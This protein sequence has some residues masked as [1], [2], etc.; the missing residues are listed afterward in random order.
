MK[1]SK[2]VYDGSPGC[3]IEDELRVC[4]EVEI[5]F[6]QGLKNHYKVVH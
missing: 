2:E 4:V 6:V 1:V 3:S 5:L